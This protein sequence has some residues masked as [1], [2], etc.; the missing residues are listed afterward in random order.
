MKSIL[1]F[2]QKMDW[3]WIAI[4][5]LGVTLRFWGI[6]FGLPYTYSSDE[7]TY[8]ITMLQIIRS[9]DLNPH[10]WLYPS[11]MFYLN[12]FALLGYWLVGRFFGVFATPADLPMPGGVTMGGGQRSP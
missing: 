10:W 1:A 6:N 8:L 7:P 12:V 2:P 5:L 9:G 3:K 11:L 4:L